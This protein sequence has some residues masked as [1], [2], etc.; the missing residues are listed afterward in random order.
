[1]KEPEL[2]LEKRCN[3]VITEQSSGSLTAVEVPMGPPV[4]EEKEQQSDEGADNNC[5]TGTIIIKGG[6]IE[7]EGGAYW[8]SYS[9][10]HHGGAG[11]GTGRYESAEPLNTGWNDNRRRRKGDRSRKS[12]AEWVEV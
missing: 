9:T 2:R 6:T 4:S 10:D 3:T 11:I 7:A 1:M 5:R 8:V 12:E